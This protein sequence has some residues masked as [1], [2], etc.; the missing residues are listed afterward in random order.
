MNEFMTPPN[1][2]D[3]LAKPLF[4]ECGQI[5]NGSI[6]YL[7][8]NGGGP[9]EK[10]THEHNHLFIVTQG[11]AKILLGDET[12]IIRKNE[13]F[14]V[15]GK[16]PHSVWNNIDGETVMIGISISKMKITYKKAEIVDAELLIEIY[17][18][19]F[20]ADY[21]RY[22]ECPAYGRTV[23]HMKYSI[24]CYS[25]YIILCNDV[26]VGVLS[27]EN[28]GNGV[29][30]VGCL[31]I[32][33]EYQGKG[34]GTKAFEYMQNICRD[35]RRIELVTPADKTENIKFYTQK[36]GMTVGKSKWDGKVEVVELYIEKQ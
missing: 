11:E 9:T 2:I 12:V 23:E 35:Y 20:Y 15:D 32:I 13:S 31:C 19:S 24:E 8:P 14:L 4:E 36:C 3:F 27:F 25:K 33:P 28:K 34:I 29:Y 17:N 7:S 16:I 6:A 10:H 1:H 21:V 5:I 26:P 30:Y 18:Q 22:G